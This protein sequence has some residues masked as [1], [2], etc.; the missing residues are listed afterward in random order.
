MSR[1]SGSEK[2]QENPDQTGMPLS[3]AADLFEEAHTRWKDR[4]QVHYALLRALCTLTRQD[5][6]QA[7]TGFTALEIH[8]AMQAHRK[9]WQAH[10]DANDI[11]AAVRKC[12]KKLQT[13]L[14]GKAE[15]LSEL[16][17]DQGWA[18]M[19]NIS[20]TEGGGAGN[21]PRYRLTTKPLDAAPTVQ[22][23]RPGAAASPDVVHYICEDSREQTGL[24]KWF[25]VI[26]MTGWRRGLFL[27][28]CI[29]AILLGLLA[30]F[31]AVVLGF[32]APMSLQTARAL[33]SLLL[34]VG[35]IYLSVGTLLQV[36]FVRILS[37]P[38][39]LQGG[40]EDR[41]LEWR[42]PPRHPYKSLHLVRYS[43]KCPKCGG[44]VRIHRKWWFLPA[45]LIGRCEDAP[46]VHVFTF[47]H[48]L[49]VGH[50]V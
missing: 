19:P 23:F 10:A 17:R 48:V 46:L 28:I 32:M 41:L 18:A 40:D 1:D 39:L 35:A 29:T 50:P 42:C 34:I 47:D 45:H 22:A 44:T 27:T 25:A 3:Q 36:V 30:V 8:G 33:I 38:F 5:P 4:D 6:A 15:H 24:L 20:R 11:S 16:A 43:G 49:R 26:K 9:G 2:H 12:F 7:E 14:A 31:T 21:L 13:A 37:A